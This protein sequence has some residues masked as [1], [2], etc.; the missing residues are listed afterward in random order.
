MEG[1]NIDP[2]GFKP[3]TD[4]EI[5]ESE[6]KPGMTPVIPQTNALVPKKHPNIPVSYLFN[7][8][9]IQTTRSHLNFYKGTP[10]S[11]PAMGPND[12][13]VKVSKRSNSGR[14]TFLNRVV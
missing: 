3:L 9:P 4:K 2:L 5:R 10:G 12:A 7:Q 1:S 11:S 13:P 14:T 6:K 8:H